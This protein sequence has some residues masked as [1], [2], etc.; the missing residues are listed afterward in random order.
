MK[1]SNAQVSALASKLEDQMIKENAKIKEEAF[2]KFQKSATTKSIVTAALK[3]VNQVETNPI[4]KSLLE[5]YKWSN[6]KDKTQAAK[7]E[8]LEYKLF[9]NSYEP[10]IRKS[11]D[12]ITKEIMIASI[13]VKDL[14]EL[15]NKLG[16]KL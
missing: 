2:K 4:L 14:S 11:R 6:L 7:R 15:S 9:S 13:D 3:L 16:Y 5:D 12:A 1:L 10:P 8:I